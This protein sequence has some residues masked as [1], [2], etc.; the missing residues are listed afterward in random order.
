PY[1]QTI[2]V[3]SYQNEKD[4]VDAYASGNVESIHGV[5]PQSDPKIPNT[6]SSLVRAPL[7]RVFGLFFNQNVAPVFVNKEVRQALSMS[8]DKQ[9]IVDD[10]L[11]TFGQPID[12]PVPPKT[13]A[14]TSQDTFT[15]TTLTK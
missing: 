12:E 7:P 2:I 13:I 9:Q 8:V 5:L 10:V 4:L 11:H 3:K 15:A 6:G 1:I 14:D